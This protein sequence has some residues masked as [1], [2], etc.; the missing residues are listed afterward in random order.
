MQHFCTLVP[1]R[2]LTALFTLVLCVLAACTDPN[3]IKGPTNITGPGSNNGTG[4]NTDFA[5]WN[6]VDV[7]QTRTLANG[8]IVSS[9]AVSGGNMNK[10]LL[11][12]TDTLGGLV[13]FHRLVQ[14]SSAYL[15]GK[16]NNELAVTC[17]VP[18]RLQTT[19]PKAEI[20]VAERTFSVKPI[21]FSGI[22]ANTWFGINGEVSSIFPGATIPQGKLTANVYFDSFRLADN[23][24]DIPT[25]SVI[26]SPRD[27]AIIDRS[28]GLTIELAQPITFNAG[29]SH[30]EITLFSSFG[31]NSGIDN[32]I[33]Q[34]LRPMAKTYGGSVP[35]KSKSQLPSGA[36]WGGKVFNKI[37]P[38]G[39]QKIVIPA[40][41]LQALPPGRC[42]VSIIITTVKRFVPEQFILAASGNYECSYILR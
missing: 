1:G 39:T 12:D 34:D 23:A 10:L 31:L 8:V 21:F 32:N 19:I 26:V 33:P 29:E 27:S 30:C 16:E 22:N 7:S 6:G 20:N 25:S 38:S 18:E 41:A 14:S 5:A 15:Q 37:L 11:P 40:Q 42:L 3:T 9:L 2:V 17:F 28:N 13:Q 35:E 36:G 24:I 4:N